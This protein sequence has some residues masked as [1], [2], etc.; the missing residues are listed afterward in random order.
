MRIQH[1]HRRP[2]AAV[3][4]SM[5]CLALLACGGNSMG[6]KGNP[7]NP[8]HPNF[9]TSDSEADANKKN[10][11]NTPDAQVKTPT[12]ASSAALEPKTEPNSGVP[13][14]VVTSAPQL[15][16]GKA[17]GQ[18][19][20]PGDL[21]AGRN[22]V[23][24]IMIL[25]FKSGWFAGD[26][27]QTF[28]KITDHA[29]QQTI[30][31]SYAHVIGNDITATLANNSESKGLFS[32]CSV[33][34]DTS[35]KELPEIYETAGCELGSLKGFDQLF[36]LSGSESDVLDLQITD[37]EFIK[38]VARVVEF[39]KGKS[40]AGIFLG[41]GLNNVT[42]GNAFA[43]AL[44]PEWALAGKL[45]SGIETPV[46]ATMPSPHLPEWFAKG[47]LVTGTG[48]A[49][50]TFNSAHPLFSELSE[51]YDYKKEAHIIAKDAYPGSGY[52]YVEK[53]KDANL[54]QCFGDK[55]D[56]SK[57]TVLATDHCGQP[58]IGEQVFG[59]LHLVVDG[60]MARFYGADA[61]SYF[62]RIMNEFLRQ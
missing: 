29:C 1:P 41:A 62:A 48:K 2:V 61:Q 57:V 58:M 25:D 44:H 34:K 51:L 7:G 13:Q 9:P 4:L 24:K 23:V 28:T 5:S 36:L 27:G 26:G 38:I 30:Q 45:F 21:C 50:G 3:A 22:E 52:E 54:G 20:V 42:H 12:A 19:T 17:S 8:P 15:P 40:K 55:L 47:S 32:K 33:R 53:D 18:T 10:P 60:N 6:F 11:I 35:G 56:A 37:P 43:V 31:V 14:V 46:P 16:A 39:S 49:P 59:N